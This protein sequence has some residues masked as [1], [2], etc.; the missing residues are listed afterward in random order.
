MR[1]ILTTSE[2]SDFLS[3][4]QSTLSRMRRKGLGPDWFRIGRS[5]V[6]YSRDAV[7]HWVGKQTDITKQANQKPRNQK[8]E[9]PLKGLF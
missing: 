8:N 1:A 3:T 9:D 5:G 6:R 2:V 7:L 4:S